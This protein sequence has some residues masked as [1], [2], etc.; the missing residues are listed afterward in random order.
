[1]KL[2]PD[3]I[4]YNVD[5]EGVDKVRILSVNKPSGTCR[6]RSV[7]C[8]WTYSTPISSLYETEQTAKKAFEKMKKDFLLTYKL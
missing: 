2:E 8:P 6:I 1:M 4:W 7:E 3:T 5:W